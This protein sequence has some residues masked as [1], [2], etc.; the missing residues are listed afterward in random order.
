MEGIQNDY[1]KT[2]LIQY[3]YTKILHAWLGYRGECNTF[4]KQTLNFS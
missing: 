1:M 3:T 2:R 4:Y